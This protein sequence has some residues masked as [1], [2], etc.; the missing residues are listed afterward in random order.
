MAYRVI[1]YSRRGHS[2]IAFGGIAEYSTA[3]TLAAQL[4]SLRNLAHYARDYLV[5][6]LKAL[7]DEVAL[8][9]ADPGATVAR[10]FGQDETT[11]YQ[12]EID[13]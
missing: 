10:K 6:P 9:R 5:S 2:S 12:V 11:D 7:R 8:I 13:E 3:H 1:R 4:R